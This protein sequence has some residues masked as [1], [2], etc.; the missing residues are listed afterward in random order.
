[1][2][3]QSVIMVIRT[4]SLAPALWF[5]NIKRTS[6][7]WGSSYTDTVHTV[8]AYF[9]KILPLD[10]NS[11][12]YIY[13]EKK[14]TSRQLLSETLFFF[15]SMMSKKWS[16]DL[17]SYMSEMKVSNHGTEPVRKTWTSFELWEI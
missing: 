5:C 12:I 9:F 8:Q 15:Y 2:A 3:L 13:K 6:E 10:T 14:I 7:L 11:L 4:L 16:V 1:M 17:S